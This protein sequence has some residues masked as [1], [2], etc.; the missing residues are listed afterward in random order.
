MKRQVSI[1]GKLLLASLFTVVLWVT[2]FTASAQAPVNDDCSGAITLNVDTICSMDT[3]DNFNATAS[4]GV[5]NPTCGFYQGGD[6]WFKVTV[7][8]SGNIRF[9]VRNVSGINPQYAIYTGSCGSLTQY[10]CNQL[11]ADRT[12]SDPSLAN[13]T[14]YIRVYKYNNASGGTF[15]ICVWEPPVPANDNCADAI[16]LNV[17]TS[18]NKVSYTSLYSTGESTTVAPNPTC[19]FYQGGD[20]W[21]KFVMPASGVVRFELTGQAPQ[22]AVYS[23]SCGSFTQLHCAQLNYETM[24]VDTSLAGDTLYLRTYRY[25]SEEGGN[26]DICIWEPTIPANNDCGNA[27]MLSV[28][29]SCSMDTF[30]NAYATK[31]PT[32]V[33]PNPTCGFYQGGDV[34]FKFVAPASGIFRVERQN[35][36]ANAQYAVYS[37]SCGSFTQVM[38]AQLDAGRTVINPALGGDTLYLRVYSYNSEEG[39]GFSICI[40]EPDIPVND[41]CADAI[42]LNAGSSC[43]M[44]TFVNAYASAEATSIAPN[45]TC[46][47]YQGGDVWF[48]FVMPASGN[49]RV[50]KQDFGMNAQYAVY[51]GSCGSFTQLFCAQLDAGKTYLDST[52]AGDTLYLRVYN[53][54]NDEGGSF[55]ICV[56]DPPIPVNNHCADAIPLTVG[57]SC[58]PANFTNRYST[59]EPTSVAP[60]PTCGFYNGSDV[61][62]TVQ[63][64][65]S[66]LLTIQRQNLANVNAQMALYSGTCGSFTQLACA[67][68]NSTLNFADTSFIGQTLYLRV[69]NYNSDEGGE[70][71]V[72]AFNPSPAIISQSNDTTICASNNAYFSVTATNAT[73]YQ[74]Q[75]NTGGGWSDVSNGGVYSGASTAT[76]NFTNVPASMTGYQYR[77]IVSGIVSPPDVSDPMTLTVGTAPLFTSSPGTVTVYTP[78]NTCNAIAYY[79]HTVTGVPSPYVSYNFSGATAGSSVGTG[80]GKYF[81]IGNT[82]VL[83]TASNLCGVDSAIHSVTVI[84]TLKPVI[85]CASGITI[86]ADNGNCSASNVNLTQP[87]YADACGIDTLYNDAPAT[88]PVGT[89][90]VTWT[91]VDNNGNAATCTQSVTVVDTTAPTITCTSS[92]TVSSD[93]G[94]C[95]ASNVVIPQPSVFDVCGVDTIFTNEPPTYSFGPTPVVIT[96]IDVNGNSSTCTTTVNVTDTQPPIL[97]VGNDIFTTTDSGSCTASNVMLNTPIASDNCSLVSVTD[98]APPV[99]PLGNTTV[100]VTATDH[101]GQQ[102]TGTYNVNVKDITPPTINAGA[103]LVVEAGSNCNVPNSQINWN[104]IL[105]ISDNCTIGNTYSNAPQ[106]YGLGTTTVV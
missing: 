74:W 65:S 98:N 21:F 25:N 52:V 66:G 94:L 61:W 3:F 50:D 86:Q 44:D 83:V 40:W 19:G 55:S 100:T 99:F 22:Y 49:L 90:V 43:N 64:P 72:C 45:P 5:P 53:Y 78:S 42:W 7:P 97:S 16:M 88:F 71:T 89:T 18:C 104:S 9:E 13:Q 54:N 76:L 58:V 69:F 14:L 33:A 73:S 79:A 57:S 8:A 63:M 20:V 28:G 29:T 95:T 15:Q 77:C 68:L 103:D 62:F 92:I 32:S 106:F 93:S 81:G 84:D 67:Q 51:S 1:V 31:E 2:S 24:L 60:N 6:V 56:W 102:T 23:G 85:Y 35:M 26:F 70:F 36:G 34:W 48:K 11:D 105:S 41:N 47:F 4:A 46:G 17:G 38:C 101:L 80:S 75:E 91:I 96:A 12:I 37:G 87:T 27:I 39:G 30:S 10:S 82:T 59:R